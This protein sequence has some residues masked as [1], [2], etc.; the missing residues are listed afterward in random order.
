MVGNSDTL[1]TQP[2]ACLFSPSPQ[3]KALP[4]WVK[5]T[6]D[7]CGPCVCRTPQRLMRIPLQSHGAPQNP[8]RLATLCRR[9]CQ[10]ALRGSPSAQPAVTHAPQCAPPPPAGRTRRHRGPRARRA[11]RGAPRAHCG[12][13]ACTE[14]GS[15]TRLGRWRSVP[16]PPREAAAVAHGV[17]G[18]VEAEKSRCLWPGVR[19]NRG[20]IPA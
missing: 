3:N 1:H 10:V 20:L 15:R 17:S 13:L 11:A 2:C 9:L 19:G 14:S 6:A 8:A 16:E 7:R 5:G 18:R 12:L 4:D